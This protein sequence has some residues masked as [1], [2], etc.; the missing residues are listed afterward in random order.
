MEALT[1][2]RGCMWSEPLFR[3]APLLHPHPRDHSFAGLSESD[4]C[5]LTR[6]IAQWVKRLS[7]DLR[8]RAPFPL[9]AETLSVVNDG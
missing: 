7:A 3:L 9:E 2:V 6:P 5:K 1:R 8:S 4:L